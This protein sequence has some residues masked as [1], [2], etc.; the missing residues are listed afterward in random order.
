MDQSGTDIVRE[1]ISAWPNGYDTL[2]RLRTDDFIED[3]PQSGERI[4]GDAMYR[5]IH[6]HYPGGLPE[7]KPG[8]VSGTPEQWALSPSFTLVHL[9]GSGSTFTV[10]GALDYPDGSTYMVVAVLEL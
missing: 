9:T 6:E 10:E 4:R 1:Y 7:Y 8:R 5:A 3:W 2:T